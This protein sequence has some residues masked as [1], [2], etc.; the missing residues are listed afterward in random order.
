MEKR[1]DEKGVVKFNGFTISPT[2]V[3]SLKFIMR[4]DE[5]ITSINLLQGLQS[6]ITI[7]AKVP[8][9]KAFS[10]GIFN[11]GGVSFDK[12]GNA[13]ITFK[14]MT[15]NVNLEEVCSLANEELIQVKF[16]AVLELPDNGGED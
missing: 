8:D 3:V 15:D 1:L 4:Y 12:D 2:R 7:H 16:L 13:K 10:L 9:R 5:I 6:D 14:S 11:V